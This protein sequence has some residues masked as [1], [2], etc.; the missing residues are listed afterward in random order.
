MWHIYRG[1]VLFIN[2]KDHATTQMNLN[3]IMKS[4]GSQMNENTQSD[5]VYMDVHKRQMERDIK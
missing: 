4:E 5:S 2:K 1:G 3:N